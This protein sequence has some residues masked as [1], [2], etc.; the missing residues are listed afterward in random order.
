MAQLLSIPDWLTGNFLEKHLQNH[1]KNTTI[2]VVNF[3]VKPPSNDG[4]FAS[5]IYRVH[6]QFNTVATEVDTQAKQ[7]VSW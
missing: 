3:L 7:E 4:N 5:K 1:F 2:G 6:V